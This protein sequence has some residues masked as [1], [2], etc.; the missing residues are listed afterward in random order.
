MKA[1]KYDLIV[2]RT[3]SSFGRIFSDAAE[4]IAELPF[5][6]FLEAEGILSSDEKYQDIVNE[7]IAEDT[8]RMST[9]YLKDAPHRSEVITA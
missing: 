8:K 5:P 6:V 7:L 9:A 2:A 4:R 3:I 1:G